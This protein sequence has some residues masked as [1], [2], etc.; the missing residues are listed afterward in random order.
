MVIYRSFLA[1]M[2][3]ETYNVCLLDGKKQIDKKVNLLWQA[4]NTQN[5]KV[6][7][8]LRFITMFFTYETFKR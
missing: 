2:K 8:K 7:K 1:E 6:P 3:D 5:P 4:E